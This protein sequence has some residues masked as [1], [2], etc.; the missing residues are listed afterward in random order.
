M[1]YTIAQLHGKKGEYWCFKEEKTPKTVFGKNFKMVSQ[2][3]NYTFRV[4]WIRLKF[5][6]KST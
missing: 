4:G 3:V 6:A 5:F 1:I 2:S